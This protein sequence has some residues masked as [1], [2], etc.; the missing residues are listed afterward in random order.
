MVTQDE[1]PWDACL[2]IFG[3]INYG[4]RVTDDNDR[5]CLITNLTKYCKQES[6]NDHY[7]YSDQGI[8]Y[9]PVDGDIKSY[10][11]YIETFPLNDY[12]TIF[13]M[14]YNANITAMQNDS[15][16]NLNTILDI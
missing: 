12:P 13:G 8:Y 7:P 1:V 6:L 14:H 2:Y 11:D 10:R 4:G 15:L 9:T 5:V 3:H 16:N